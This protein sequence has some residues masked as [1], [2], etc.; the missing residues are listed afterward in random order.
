MF[1]DLPPSSNVSGVSDSAAAAI[2]RRAVATA[3]G[4]RDLVDAGVAHQRVAG[5]RAAGDH[6]E[7]ARRKPGFERELGEA[8]RAERRD[9]RRLHTTVLPAASAGATLW[10]MPIIGPF[11]GT[12]AAIT[13]YGSGST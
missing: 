1:A 4:E 3:A 11:H 6:V 12:I 5:R 7:H 2:T 10:P 13:P 9:L 8:Q